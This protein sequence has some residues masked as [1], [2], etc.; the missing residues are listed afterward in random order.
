MATVRK[1]LQPETTTDV[2]DYRS[3]FTPFQKAT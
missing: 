1:S 3:T 2:A